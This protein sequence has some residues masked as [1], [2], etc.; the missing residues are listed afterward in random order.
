MEK[1]KRIVSIFLVVLML[2]TSLPMNVF[3][4]EIASVSE[5]STSQVETTAVS[6]E[7][8]SQQEPDEE[9]TTVTTTE[10]GTTTGEVTETEE[11][12]TE[13]EEI[14]YETEMT[15]TIDGVKYQIH[16]SGEVYVVG[17]TSDVP[18]KL[19][20]PSHLGK[21]P[22]TA[23][24]YSAFSMGYAENIK[25]IIIPET[26]KT[27]EGM[28]GTVSLEKLE[29]R[30]DYVK[31]D[32]DAFLKSP[33]VKNKDNW[34][35]D[36]L[37][38]GSCLL[39]SV[40]QG[41]I[42][43]GKEITS[44]QYGAFK[45]N[46]QVIS[47]LN[48][49]C[50]LYM[51]SSAFPGNAV[52]RGTK[53]S[54]IEKYCNSFGKKAFEEI[55]LC[56]GG[57][58]VE[59]TFSRCDG[60][61]GYTA[62]VYCEKCQLWQ[63]G[64]L[65]K[66]QIEHIDENNDRICDYC[67]SGLDK[68]IIALGKAG[69]SAYWVLDDEGTISF[70]GKG[71]LYSYSTAY[72]APW[73]SYDKE[74]LIKK[75]VFAKGIEALGERYFYGNNLESVV[76]ADTV[77][78]INGTFFLCCDLKT[79][80]MSDS[81]T[82]IGKDSFAYCYKLE[83]ISLP[84]TLTSIGENAFVSCKTLKEIIIPDSITVIG[85]AAFAGCYAA[86]TLRLPN[87]LQEIGDDCF[88]ACTSLKALVIPDTVTDIGQKGFY[89]CKALTDVDLPEG[90]LYIRAYAFENCEA[91]TSITVPASVKGIGDK[92]F[93]NCTNLLDINIEGTATLIGED[94]FKG[95]AAY[96]NAD[97]IKDGFL[98]IDDYL[99]EEITVGATELI[100][101]AE[102][103][104]IARNWFE[105][106]DTCVEE[107]TVYN[108]DCVFPTTSAGAP[109]GAILKGLVGSTTEVYAE[110]YGKNFIPFCICE[111]TLVTVPET[112]GYC[113]GTRGYTEGVWCE[114]CQLWTAG[115]EEKNDFIHID[116]NEDLIC[117]F[118]KEST[119]VK[120]VSSGKAGENI[121]W[122]L[123]EDGTLYFEGTGKMFDYSGISIPGWLLNGITIKRVVM[124]GGITSIANYAFYGCSN[125]TEIELSPVL[126]EIGVRAFYNCSSLTE[127]ELPEMLSSIGECA[128]YGCKSIKSVVLHELVTT[129]GDKI[130]WNCTGLESVEIKSTNIITIPTYMFYNCQSLVTFKAEKDIKHVEEKA[131]YNCVS[132]VAFD[133]TGLHE[134]EAKA[135]YNC[136]SLKEIRMKSQIDE[137]SE[138][139][140]R[141]CTSLS[142]LELNYYLKT[143]YSCAFMNCRSLESVIIPGKV[144]T[145][146][147]GAFAACVKLKHI[148]VKSDTI[149]I[150]TDTV[151][152]AGVKYRPFPSGATIKA[153]PTSN[154]DVYADKYN[155]KFE[156]L[157]EKEITS[158]VLSKEPSK[159][160]YTVGKD[161]AFSKSGARVTVTYS[162]GKSITL[163][164]RFK[165]NW[166]DADITKSG[167]Y[168]PCIVYG[169]YELPFEITVVENYIFNGVPESR[170]FGA[171]FCPKNETVS[172]CFIPDKTGEYSFCFDNASGVE[173]TSD[174]SVRFLGYVRYTKKYVYEQGKEYYI[175]L[176]ST[177]SSKTVRVSEIDDVYFTPLADGSYEAKLCVGTG[178]VVIPN[179]YAGAPVTK[180][181]DNFMSS[182]WAELSSVTLSEGIT[183]IGTEAF[184][185]YRGNVV[186]SSTVKKIGE[187]AFFGCR[188]INKFT[189]TES[190]TEIGDYA[191]SEC[192]EL[193]ELTILPSDISY[194][195]KV[196]SYCERLKKVNLNEE[197]ES[198][199]ELMFI[200]CERLLEIT[201]TKSLRSIGR[202]AFYGCSDLVRV[203]FLPQ[204]TEMGKSVFTDCTSLEEIELNNTLTEIPESAFSGCKSLVK[205]ELPDSVTVI[206]KYAFSSCSALEE[207][208]FGSGIRE[209]EERA[210]TQAGFEAIAL[211]DT[212][213]TIGEYCFGYCNKL[214][215]VTLPEKITSV[216]KECFFSCDSL[217]KVFSRGDI[218]SVEEEAFSYCE[219]L[220]ETDF[221][222]TVETI[223]CK[224]FYGCNSLVSVS[225]EKVT[226]IDAATFYS[227]DNLAQV[228]LPMKGT[229]IGVLA[230]AYTALKEIEVKE[231]S[232]EM[233]AAFAGCD[234]LEKV[235][236]GKN[237]SL[238]ETVLDY[239]DNIKELHIY[240]YMSPD[241]HIDTDKETLTIY[242]FEGGS[243]E[244][245]AKENDFSFVAVEGTENHGHSFTVTYVEPDSCY[246]PVTLVYSCDCGYSYSEEKSIMGMGPHYYGDFTVDKEPTCTEYGLK[247]KHCHC[248]MKR[249]D[250]TLIDPLGHTEII[251]IPAVAPTE[252]EPGY[253]H[254]SHCSVCGETVVK[255]ELITHEE[256]DIQIN[257]D[258]ITAHKLD[259]ATNENDGVEITITF[260]LKSQVYLSYIDK[261]VICKVGEVKLSKTRLDYNGKV[262]NPGVTVKDSTGEPLV[263][264]R[265]YKLTC[266]AGS[267]YSGKY[268]VRVDYIGNYAG[269]KTLYYDIVI[270]AVVP[271]VSSTDKSISLSWKKGHSDLY[272][273]VYSADSKGNLKK[274]A[275]TKNGSYTV[276]SLKSGTEYR[277]LVRAFVKDGNGKIYWGDKGNSVLC[278][279]NPVSVSK[280]TITPE[281][282]SVKLSWSKVSGATGYRVYKYD[283]S[284][285]MVKDTKSLSCEIGGLKSGTAY[286]FYVRPYKQY[287]G[288]TVWS[289]D[290][291]A[292]A[293]QTYTMPSATS[294]ISYTSS[295]DS[296]K[297]S[298]NKVTGATDYRIYLYDNAKDKY[299]KVAD[300]SKNSY[301]VKKKNGKKLKPGVEYKF[302]VKAYIKKNGKTYWSDSY[303]TVT[304]ATKPAKS[305]LT[306]TSSKGKVNLSWKDVMGESGYQVYYSTKKDGK[307][308]KLTSLKADK[309][310]YSKK[311]TKGK[312]Y[313]FKVRA[314]KKA[315]GKTV[316]GSFSFVKS[317]KI[318]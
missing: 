215:E 277:F 82:T 243:A 115:H 70:Y 75:A 167:V 114:R 309:V 315:G 88:K 96:S 281:T 188:G 297:L 121:S 211:P 290:N 156:P 65:E 257:D 182:Y 53:G 83:S 231:N 58:A 61:V 252:T 81:V 141:N 244:K 73:Y 208:V 300:T 49:N 86:E 216:P 98:F 305:S 162:D 137:I 119:D 4:E 253:T 190:V 59:E 206:R 180:I 50:A 174:A 219:K 84:E 301:T 266:S 247:S 223:G 140:F 313:Y 262:Q 291:K 91:L 287:S 187:K 13:A 163:T 18:E 113:D 25:E 146:Y 229:Y 255:R 62:G 201:G 310:K 155:M 263:L 159:V 54:T 153:N 56:E 143:I 74:G 100:L 102:I 199:A 39:R 236:F 45:G 144:K 46:P 2:F 133:A 72:Y 212:V 192:N 217:E 194:G 189:I 276:S 164:T 22:V 249:A 175:Q 220:V 265:D 170:T 136:S 47:F 71:E 44:V 16:K 103:R 209:I 14:E 299:V 89:G 318:K 246:T 130:F 307:Y 232:K 294:K 51:V 178:D 7:E 316:Y 282:K 264:N 12:T 171:V 110:K 191:F 11:S 142:V 31:I 36:H 240:C 99:I 258:N 111:D 296:V 198:I 177:S 238:S 237:V 151:E 242:C 108:P 221:W 248:E 66:N 43:L 230:F 292:D 55:C 87:D 60:Y 15:Y 109:A 69:D 245:F 213:E 57:T 169:D 256:Y 204:I 154:A 179:E 48:E 90:L 78:S 68:N 10:E 131:F 284:W 106:F 41:E 63:S 126:G 145:V 104:G 27:I 28:S 64:H 37:I 302:R 17:N 77:K 168:K 166:K 3:A 205:I 304:T 165:V 105:T 6:E 42:I 226:Y 293:V 241:F 202:S 94:V 203:D 9:T 120:I 267:K 112:V 23:I 150:S 148:T 235:T 117:D 134:V 278:A 289:A 312:K 30:A 29:I 132:L 152:Y 261:T 80:D 26:V 124:L 288:K 280:L 157:T 127:I 200:G 107:I 260:E 308:K 279:T 272:Y 172:I 227:C 35:G 97:N 251:D 116:E 160:V 270:G 125:L 52:L 197:T 303:K 273:C 135:F 228:S 317:V 95:T 67:E 214:K 85:K 147:E 269:S 32:N 185:G 1:T 222:D 196:F 233:G 138:D 5:E 184:S 250:I 181:A 92:A 21:Y 123:M 193:R 8:A 207:I 40:A 224:A 79:V 128:F 295:T 149:S 118:C 93:Q 33:F 275:D 122:R 311:L 268:S 20:I 158:V 285:K 139:A 274:I 161:T 314:Y 271:A 254:Q 101:G 38:V 176:K 234:N 259:A 195:T 225:F 186:L 129:L 306:V 239:C 173:I 183:E 283:G 286:K 210:F 19:E 24:T 218:V 34:T 298:W 76:I